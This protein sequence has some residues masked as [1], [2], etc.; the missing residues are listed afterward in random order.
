MTKN[1]R[2]LSFFH[3]NKMSIQDNSNVI[4]IILVGNTGVG[5]TCLIG[6]YLRHKFE[7]NIEST[8]SPAYSTQ[9]Y[10]KTDGSKIMM[11]LWDTAGQEKYHAV[12]Q[13]FFRNADIA[14]MCFTAG[15]KE[16]MESIHEWI[17][18]VKN[19][20]PECA[21]LFVATKSDLMQK[22]QAD[23]V[24][25]DAEAEFQQYKSHGVFLTSAKVRY[26]VDNVFH[27][28]GELS[29]FGDASNMHEMDSIHTSKPC[30]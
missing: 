24:I 11:Q 20:A 15:D 2:F 28:A 19:E 13:L 7:E 5:K 21:L 6:S 30:C 18:M 25:K 8:L 10:I 12:S 17:R 1:L 26:N 23:S 14:L 16:S 9:P 4:K 27:A 29:E 22:E 3:T